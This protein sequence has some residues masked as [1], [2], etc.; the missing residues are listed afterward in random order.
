MHALYDNHEIINDPRMINDRS[1][2][3]EWKSFT[4]LI[5]QHREFYEIHN[6][7][8]SFYLCRFLEFS[9][10]IIEEIR[11]GLYDVC[12]KNASTIAFQC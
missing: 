1:K 4:E 3:L 6:L 5:Y 8:L 11:M 9:T 10:Y 12:L 2:N 7:F